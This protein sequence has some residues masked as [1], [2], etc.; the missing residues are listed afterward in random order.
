MMMSEAKKYH[1]YARECLKLAEQATKA[2]I[3]ERLVGLSRVWMEAALAEEQ[4]HHHSATASS[5]EPA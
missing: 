1:A 3:R 4:Q 5:P 2:D